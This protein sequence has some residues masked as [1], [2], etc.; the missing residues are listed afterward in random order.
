MT[1]KA[2]ALRATLAQDAPDM[3]GFLETMKQD[4]GAK[5]LWVKTPTLEV[6]KQPPAGIR[7]NVPLPA[8]TWPYKPGESAAQYYSSKRKR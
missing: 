1:D 6:G 7:P 8:E 3:L 4:F 2:T 5:V